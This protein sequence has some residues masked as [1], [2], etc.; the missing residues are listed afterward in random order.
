MTL[1]NRPVRIWVDKDFAKFI[2][3]KSAS[4]GKSIFDFSRELINYDDDEKR[5]VKND[6]KYKFRF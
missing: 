3:I 6:E 4:K 5:E 1:K 2:K